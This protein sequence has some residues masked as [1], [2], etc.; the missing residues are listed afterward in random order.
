MRYKSTA[1]K[2][3]ALR[4]MNSRVRNF[5]QDVQFGEIARSIKE[6]SIYYLE[7]CKVEFMLDRMIQK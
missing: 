3:N 1:Q 7:K 4:A 5:A 2:L 6:S